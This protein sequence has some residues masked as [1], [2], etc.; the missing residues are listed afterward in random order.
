MSIEEFKARYR[1]AE[2]EAILRGNLDALDE[3]YA[4]D[5]VIHSQHFP[6]QDFKGVD[7]RKQ[8]VRANGQAFQVLKL[9]WDE[10]IGEGDTVAFRYTMRL[11]HTGA[12]PMVPV[13]PTGKEFTFKGCQFLRLKDGKVSEVFGYSDTLGM[14]QQLGVIPGK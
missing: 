13:P 1:R 9:D 4:P 7:A 11:K 8:Q 6:F 5:L 10:I 12:S 2:D 14:M 3:V